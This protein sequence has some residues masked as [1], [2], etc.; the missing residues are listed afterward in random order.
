LIYVKL[1]KKELSGGVE[2]SDGVESGRRV[3]SNH[4]HVDNIIIII[5]TGGTWSPLT[6]GLVTASL[7]V[8]LEVSNGVEVRV[9]G[10]IAVV[11]VAANSYK[12]GVGDMNIAGE[13]NFVA[14]A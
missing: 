5:R 4:Q 11:G 14:V 8:R 2:P 6:Q 12:L 7:D 9:D 13:T 3:Y 10:L 1:L